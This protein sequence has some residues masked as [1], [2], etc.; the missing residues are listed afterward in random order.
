VIG[1]LKIGE[2]VCF[3]TVYGKVWRSKNVVYPLTYGSHKNKKL[4]MWI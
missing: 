1:A 2:N 3:A 4:E